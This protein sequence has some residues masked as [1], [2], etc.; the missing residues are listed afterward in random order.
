MIAFSKK[1]LLIIVYIKVNTHAQTIELKR[2]RQ[3]D[4]KTQCTKGIIN[5]IDTVVFIARIHYHP[6]SH[7]QM[8][9]QQT[10]SSK[11]TFILTLPLDDLLK[12]SGINHMPETDFNISIPIPAKTEYSELAIHAKLMR[13]QS[14]FVTSSIQYFPEIFDSK[15][16]NGTL[17]INGKKTSYSEKHFEIKVPEC[18]SNSEDKS[19]RLNVLFFCES[20]ASPCL[21]QLKSDKLN[22]VA[23]GER[24]ASLDIPYTKEEEINIYIS[25]AA[26][27]WINQNEIQVT[28][29]TEL[30]KSLGNIKARTFPWDS[31]LQVCS[32]LRIGR[33]QGPFDPVN[34]TQGTRQ[35]WRVLHGQ[36]R[37]MLGT[38]HK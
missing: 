10:N 6:D 35:L 11:F 14:E 19:C 26:C 31:G 22:K 5:D 20:Q 24:F 27:R 34:V 37:D 15:S 36:T 21:V 38:C 18:I 17:F 29:K 8:F 33:R 28:I 32:G 23:L 9:Y 12:T 25:Y 4:A 30:S 2:Y 16:T 1:V 13:S 3:Q 7:I